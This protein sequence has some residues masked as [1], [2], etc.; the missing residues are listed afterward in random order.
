MC[1]PDDAA[2]LSNRLP[3]KIAHHRLFGD[4]G[5]RATGGASRPGAI[6]IMP[7]RELLEGTSFGPDEIKAIVE[8]FD[9]ACRTLGLR[10]RN[11]P[12]VEMI[13]QK[14]ISVASD[15]ARTAEEIQRRVLAAFSGRS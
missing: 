5:G 11:D 3:D 15:G 14:T 13:A 8:A 6:A 7:I 4:A 2:F 9:G 12:L 10:E 1:E